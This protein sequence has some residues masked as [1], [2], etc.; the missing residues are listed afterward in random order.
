[1]TGI[2][3]DSH[4]VYECDACGRVIEYVLHQD[5]LWKYTAG[6][7]V[8]AKDSSPIEEYQNE[9]RQFTN[10]ERVLSIRMDCRTRP[11]GIWLN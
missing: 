4:A 5:G 2:Q 7:C 1:M 11:E 9:D 3:T 10:S 6:G 8:I